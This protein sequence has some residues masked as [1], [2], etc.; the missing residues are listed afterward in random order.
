VVTTNADGK[1]TYKAD[2]IRQPGNVYITVDAPGYQHYE[3][4]LFVEPGKEYTVPSGLQQGL[5]RVA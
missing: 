2:N 3:Q 5:A 1:F 4:L